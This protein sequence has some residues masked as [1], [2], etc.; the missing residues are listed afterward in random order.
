MLI[1]CR[2]G[3]IPPGLSLVYCIFGLTNVRQDMEQC[4]TWEGNTSGGWNEGN[5]R[6]NDQLTWM[7]FDRVFL[8]NLAWLPMIAIV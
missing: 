1:V 7:A 4:G 3:G 8:L 5:K 6:R 2:G